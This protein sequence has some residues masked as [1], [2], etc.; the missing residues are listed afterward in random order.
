MAITEAGDPGGVDGILDAILRTNRAA[1]WPSFR[2]REKSWSGSGSGCLGWAASL[3]AQEC[4]IFA[5]PK[6]DGVWV[7]KDWAKPAVVV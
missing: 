5:E 4:S 2:M 3:E 1:L 7:V 6:K